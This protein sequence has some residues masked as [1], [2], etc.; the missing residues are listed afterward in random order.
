MRSLF[1]KNGTRQCS[2]PIA[3]ILAAGNGY[4][5]QN[6]SNAIPKPEI[7]V[8]GLSL[9][10]RSIA[11]LQDAGIDRFVIVLGAH[12]DRVRGHFESI[13]K[14]RNCPISFIV[15]KNWIRGNGCSVAAAESLVGDELFLLTMVDHLLSRDLI[16][17]LLSM[18]PPSKGIALAVDYD[19]SH[20][21]DEAD[22][23]KVRI[24][25][26]YIAGI[27]KDLEKWDAGDTGLF[28]CTG[29]LFRG[30]SRAQQRGGFSLTDGI[31]ECLTRGVRAIDV[32]GSPWIDVDTPETVHKAEALVDASLTKG[33][34]DGYVSQYLNRPISRAI[35]KVLSRTSLSPNQIS[36]GC[37]LLGLL[38]AAALSVTY[39][40]AWVVG[41]LAIQLASIVDGCDGEIARIKFLHSS[42]GAWLD[43]MLDRYADLAVGVAVTFAASQQSSALW[44]WPAGLVATMSFLLASYVTKEYELRFGKPYPNNVFNRLKRRD[45]RVL[46]IAVGALLGQ[47]FPALLTIGSLTHLAILWIMIDAWRNAGQSVILK[48]LGHLRI[49]GEDDPRWEEP[50]LLTAVAR[51]S[52]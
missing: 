9:A 26:E 40:W 29:E 43:T 37:F 16:L 50:E 13:A 35:S 21:F 48:S 19:K 39:A 25:N 46:V 47:P 11:Q 18:P 38:G 42:R 32:T 27:G 8:R 52:E 4:R 1:S 23:T 12:A 34:E 7:N 51:S 30:L 45:L 31:R 3:V 24:K 15:A 5:M 36:V 14:R 49:P 2:G 10:E 20:I 41:G 44:I 17:K 22:L 6:G 28:Y 33:H